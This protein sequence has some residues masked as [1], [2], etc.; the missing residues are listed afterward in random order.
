MGQ[1]S[2]VNY[3]NNGKILEQFA[4]FYGIYSETKIAFVL[5]EQRRMGTIPLLGP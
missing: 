1:E 3:L 2:P 4:T 5:S